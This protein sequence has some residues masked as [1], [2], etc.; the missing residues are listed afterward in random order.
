VIAAICSKTLIIEVRM[1]L[2]SFSRVNKENKGNILKIYLA[3]L[4]ATAGGR[5]ARWSVALRCPSIILHSQVWYIYEL[6]SLKMES[7]REFAIRSQLT[8][9]NSWLN[10]RNEA[11]GVKVRDP[12]ALNN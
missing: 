11:P 9:N 4:S 7:L 5:L 2:Y 8:C 10:V 3:V 1:L 12:D 6:L